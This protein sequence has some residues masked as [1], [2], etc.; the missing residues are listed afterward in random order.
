VH[1]LTERIKTVLAAK[2]SDFQSDEIHFDV[3]DFDTG[4]ID[5]FTGDPILRGY[6][7]RQGQS[8]HTKDKGFDLGLD[9]QWS[10]RTLIQGRVGR[11]TSDTSYPLSNED[12]VCGNPIYLPLLEQFG[13]LLNAVCV[14]RE[15][16]KDN[17]LTADLDWNWQTER[18][19]FNL[20]ASKST[21]PSS[22]GYVVDA[23]QASANWSFSLTERD[24]LTINASL[25]R[26]RSVS[27]DAPQANAA[28]SDRDYLS[29][30]IGYRRQ[31]ADTWFADATYQYS[32]QK[33]GNIDYRANSNLFAI[34][35]RY[36]PQSW[37]WA[38]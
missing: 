12:T 20:H 10:E 24:R 13:P 4:F 7:G 31:L 35:I 1:V 28:L 11:S 8:T 17:L 32:E 19:Q 21:A 29:A 2:Y 36:Q 30:R 22:N 14:E 5:G 33:Y 3:P 23:V 6:L 9:Y 25:V 27:D 18:Q 38:R 15:G 34:G 16:S 37:H 26:N